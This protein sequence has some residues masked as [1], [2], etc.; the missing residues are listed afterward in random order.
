MSKKK[1]IYTI[2]DDC[3]PASDNNG[4]KVNPLALHVQNLKRP[5]TPYFFNTLYDPYETGTD[6]VRGYPYSLRDGVATVVSHGLW[7]TA[8]DYDAPT[9]L[10]KVT[11]RISKMHEMTVTVPYGVMYP[12]CSMNVAFDRQL[13]GP[14]FMQGLMGVGQ[15]WAR[16]DDMFAGWYVPPPR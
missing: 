16:Y 7:M 9:Q 5:A 15:P 14:A 2:D 4:Y 10:L 11:E 6:F 3:L 1:Y 12:M 8:P 13:I